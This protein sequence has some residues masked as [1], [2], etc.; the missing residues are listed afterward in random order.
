MELVQQRDAQGHFTDKMKP[1]AEL[2]AKWAEENRKA[3]LAAEAIT[4]IGLTPELTGMSKKA[5]GSETRF[6]G[7]GTMQVLRGAMFGICHGITASQEDSARVLLLIFDALGIDLN[8][9]D[10]FRRAMTEK[11]ATA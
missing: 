5:D 8:L 3:G 1:D 7:Y 2:A 11:K 9:F 10:G 4:K 6:M